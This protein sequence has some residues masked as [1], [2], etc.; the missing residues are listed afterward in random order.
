MEVLKNAL[1]E[2]TIISSFFFTANA[3]ELLSHYC[4]HL[5]V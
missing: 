1:K 3:L 2:L 4:V 5:F